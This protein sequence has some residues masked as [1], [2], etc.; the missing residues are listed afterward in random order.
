M[1]LNTIYNIITVDGT[2]IPKLKIKSIN[3]FSS[4]F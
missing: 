1:L 4:V 2:N 3:R